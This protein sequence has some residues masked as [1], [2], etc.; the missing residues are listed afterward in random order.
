MLKIKTQNR[1][2]RMKKYVLITIF[3][4]LI[5]VWGALWIKNRT[6]ATAV[7]MP[8]TNP[9]FA[10]YGR[11]ATK[12]ASA[13]GYRGGQNNSVMR[14]QIYNLT[15]TEI[16]DRIL[17][18]G[19]TPMIIFRCHMSGFTESDSDAY[20]M[21]ADLDFAKVSSKNVLNIGNKSFSIDELPVSDSNTLIVPVLLNRSV[22]DIQSPS[23]VHS[24][25][26]SVAHRIWL[27]E[28]ESSYDSP[29]ALSLMPIFQA[30]WF[31]DGNWEGTIAFFGGD[32]R[33][34]DVTLVHK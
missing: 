32:Q 1:Q 6:L 19:L 3:A 17:V 7:R 16:T 26:S 8:G 29:P 28:E 12:L 34:S 4:I 9:I 13:A 21:W 20:M 10:I 22:T 33:A 30:D 14:L 25:P 24:A 27:N 31:V 18:S 11:E 23:K 15:K 5:A 2:I